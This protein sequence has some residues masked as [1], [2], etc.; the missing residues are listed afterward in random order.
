MVHALSVERA[1]RNLYHVHHF[2]PPAR[3]PFN[4]PSRPSTRHK[5]EPFVL[6]TRQ[7]SAPKHRSGKCVKVVEVHDTVTTRNTPSPAVVS[8]SSETRWRFVRVS[9]ATTTARDPVS[10]RISGENQDG[11]IP[12]RRR[13]EP[14]LTP[15]H[16]PSPTSPRPDPSQPPRRTTA[17][18][19]LKVATYF[20]S[21]SN[22]LELGRRSESLQETPRLG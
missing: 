16:Q 20:V 4:N 1:P 19:S 9:A 3:T 12:S 13:R 11:S 21:R 6:T 18:R 17:R 15:L 10:D 22:G 7:N 2:N 8:S 5:L 14:D